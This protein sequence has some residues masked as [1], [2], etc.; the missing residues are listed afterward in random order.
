MKHLVKYILTL[1]H[2]KFDPTPKALDDGISRYG[3]SMRRPSSPLT[4]I[5][6]LNM[7][8]V[9]NDP[10][11]WPVITSLLVN[12]CFQVACLTAVVYDWGAHKTDVYRENY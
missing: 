11:L 3:H 9:L 1:L 2:T 7:T 10:S 4:D 8:I 12:S 5:N 6:P